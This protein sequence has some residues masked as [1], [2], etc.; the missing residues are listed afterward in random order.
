MNDIPPD[1]RGLNAVRVVEMFLERVRSA[2]HMKVQAI[3][4]YLLEEGEDEF[5]LHSDEVGRGFGH[6]LTLASRLL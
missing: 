6:M 4:C 1:D 3:G 5:E 2:D